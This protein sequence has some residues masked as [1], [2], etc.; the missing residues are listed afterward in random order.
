MRPWNYFTMNTPQ[1]LQ[2]ISGK[3]FVREQILILKKEQD[4]GSLRF[5]CRDQEFSSG[6]NSLTVGW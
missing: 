4:L 1:V 6:R 3:L 2:A 5:T